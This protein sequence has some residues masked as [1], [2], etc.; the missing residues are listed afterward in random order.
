MRKPILVLG[1][2]A[3]A[4]LL[5]FTAM[6]PLSPPP[7]DELALAAQPKTNAIQHVSPEKFSNLIVEPKC[8]CSVDFGALWSFGLGVQCRESSD[9][10]CAGAVAG[11]TCLAASSYGVDDGGTALPADLQLTCN[12]R[13]TGNIKFQVCYRQT[14]AG[15][16]DLGAGLFTG[17]IIH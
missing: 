13:S 7:F 10:V 9:C 16:L 12:V 1:I 6:V 4:S 14:D 15:T 17:R 11:D 3:V 2:L 5:A 8:T